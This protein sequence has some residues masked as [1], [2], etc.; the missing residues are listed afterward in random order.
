MN[1][2]LLSELDEEELELFMQQL[3]DAARK[4][5]RI[6]WNY[7][8]PDTPIAPHHY[9]WFL[10]LRPGEGVPGNPDGHSRVLII[11]PRSW[12]KTAFVIRRVLW[13]LGHNPDQFITIVS[14]DDGHA[15]NILAEIARNIERNDALHEV[16]P[17]LWPGD[18]WQR[19]QINVVRNVMSK[20]PSVRAAGLFSTGV[21]GRSHLI[22]FDDVVA[23]RTARGLP[24]LR[25]QSKQIFHEVWMN[26]LL[27][28]GRAMSLC[29]PWHPRDLNMDLKASGDWYVWE[30]P[31]L[32]NEKGEPD[33]GG[34]STW[35][36]VWPTEA[37]LETVSYTHL[38]LPTTPY[39]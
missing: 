30:R 33:P 18:I 4:D 12:G 28:G 37:L 1:E 13:E 26:Y 35:P 3:L 19:T 15:T 21:G 8:W 34:E 31:A 22:I 27:P 6:F 16:F 25:D 38:T 7:C 2:E 32:V 10:A 5:F 20:D 39:V 14:C 29:T 11:A 9:E 17:G 23:W 24:S 36:E